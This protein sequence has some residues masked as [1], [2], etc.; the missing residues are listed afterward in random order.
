MIAMKSTKIILAIVLFCLV[1]KSLAQTDTIRL[2]RD[3]DFVNASDSV[4]LY[5]VILDSTQTGLIKVID[6]S[7]DGK[8]FFE[9]YVIFLNSILPV[10]EYLF[11]RPENEKVLFEGKAEEFKSRGF[12]NFIEKNYYPNGKPRAVHSVQYGIERFL[13]GYDSSGHA[14]IK[15]GQGHVSYEST[16]DQLT[17][18]GGI[19]DNRRNG[20]WKAVD[21]T[22]RVV[23]QETYRSGRLLRGQTFSAGGT[24]TYDQFSNLLPANFFR[25]IKR[26]V[27]GEIKLQNGGGW[28]KSK[29]NICVV[30]KNGKLERAIHLVKT[31]KEKKYNLNSVTLPK[32]LTIKEKGLP[33]MYELLLIE[34]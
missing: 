14:T 29:Q 27:R 34:I 23:H 12:R 18:S 4:Y 1:L 32:D 26:N 9:G 6:Y 17:W 19:S 33:I 20:E 31:S 7:P 2:R 8:K 30:I 11:F 24:Y 25:Q 22:N 10:K 21:A 28:P 5:R 16:H 13:E 15:Q 3:Y